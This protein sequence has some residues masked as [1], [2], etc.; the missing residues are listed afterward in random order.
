M[1]VNVNQKLAN[2]FILSETC[3]RLHSYTTDLIESGTDLRRI[4]KLLGITITELKQTNIKL[5]KCKKK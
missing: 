4:K 2:A 1:K 3:A 5:F